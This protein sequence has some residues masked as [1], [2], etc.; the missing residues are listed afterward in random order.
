MKS[1]YSYKAADAESYNSLAAYIVTSGL[2]AS[3]FP[4]LKAITVSRS[5]DTFDDEQ[6]DRLYEFMDKEGIKCEID[7]IKFDEENIDKLLD[8]PLTD[9]WTLRRIFTWAA[10]RCAKTQ[11]SLSRLKESLASAEEAR[12]NAESGQETYYKWWKEEEEKRAKLEK[13]VKAFQTL[14]NTVVE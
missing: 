8:S 1:T 3:L 12:K 5:V 6:I 14:I 4:T 11:G 9:Q 13:C 2:N 10:D 7:I